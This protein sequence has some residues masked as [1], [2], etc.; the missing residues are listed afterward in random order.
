MCKTVPQPDGLYLCS[1]ESLLFPDLN[2]NYP[3]QTFISL[4]NGVERFVVSKATKRPCCPH[5]K[6]IALCERNRISLLPDVIKSL[7][8]HVCTCINMIQA[9]TSK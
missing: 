5:R 4:L 9:Q 3:A 8:K 7:S 6:S 2:Q 1:E